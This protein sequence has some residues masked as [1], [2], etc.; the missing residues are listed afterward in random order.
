MPIA[1]GLGNCMTKGVTFCP[2]QT[3]T[4]LLEFDEKRFWIALFS[5]MARREAAHESMI[6]EHLASKSQTELKD[7]HPYEQTNFRVVAQCSGRLSHPGLKAVRMNQGTK[8]RTELGKLSYA[9]RLFTLTRKYLE[10][11]L[12]LTAALQ[13]AEADLK[14]FVTRA[15]YWETEGNN[16]GKSG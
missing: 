7:R 13:A 3:M 11:S 2:P 8:A 6:R 16:T 12:P 10:L 4:T 1:T 5:I 15:D 9:E 14:G